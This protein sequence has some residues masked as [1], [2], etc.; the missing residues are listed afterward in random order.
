[1]KNFVTFLFLLGF[2]ACSSSSEEPIFHYKIDGLVNDGTWTIMIYMC[3]DNDLEPYALLDLNEMVKTY[4]K[5][6]G[7]EVIL[8][9]DRADNSVRGSTNESGAFEENFTDTRLYRMRENAVQR[10]DGEVWFPE[11]TDSGYYEANMGDPNNLKK[12]I[13]FS[14]NN[15][16][17]EKYALIFWDHGG[18]PRS[19][20]SSPDIS[21]E[22][23]SDF[24][25][26]DSLGI[27]E[28]SDYLTSDESVELMGF[29]ACYMGSVEVAYQFAP[30]H[31]GFYAKIMVASADEE[32]GPG[33]DY[34]RIFERLSSI[35]EGYYTDEANDV[36]EET[37]F[38][39][40]YDPYTMNA[41]DF[42]SI[43]VEEYYDS[44]TEL[45]V[46]G[47]TLSAYNLN[48]IYRLKNSLDSYAGEIALNEEEIIS[49]RANFIHYF[50]Y[51]S[52]YSQLEYPFF[53]LYSIIK[54]ISSGLVPDILDVIE[55]IDES[56]L[57]SFGG[58][59]SRH[60]NFVNGLS[61]L[62]LFFPDGDEFY[63]IEGETVLSW[64]NQSW[65]NP[66]K[67]DTGDWYGNLY[68]CRDNAIASNGLVENWFEILEFWFGGSGVD[69][70]NYNF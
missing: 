11:I 9:V 6:R 38:E 55:L 35:G 41:A 61:G 49:N 28:I 2:C 19:V 47:Q 22:I 51:D 50:N 44:I 37:P 31:E 67:L 70:N 60:E 10:L 16:P 54:F 69:A 68:W 27:G 13:T 23:C 12:F 43:I 64:D 26:D 36:I 65:Y 39:I 57:F 21:R 53:D 14:K 7:Y 52:P 18:G 33:W 15:Y 5:D 8:L 24:T 4:T 34:S 63:E 30:Q 46:S 40:I 25:D 42:A 66:Q 17:S 1:M 56:V 3:A 20:S 45:N 58:G 29:D 48:E 62:S 32:W 59:V